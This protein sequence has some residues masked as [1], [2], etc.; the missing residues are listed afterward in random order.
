MSFRERATAA[1]KAGDLPALARTLYAAYAAAPA[2]AL[3]IPLDMMPP[4]DIAERPFPEQ[5]NQAIISATVVAVQSIASV[6]Q[7]VGVVL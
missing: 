2:E 1:A 7:V 3:T 5:L 6:T 4:E